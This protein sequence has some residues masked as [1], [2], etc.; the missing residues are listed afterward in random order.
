MKK[1]LFAILFSLCLLLVVSIGF[2]ACDGE[3]STVLNEYQ[4]T[5]AKYVAY[6]EAIGETPLSYEQWL[7]SIKGEDG[8]D[9]VG[10]DDMSFNDDG[11]LII[12]LTD[13]S[14]MNLGKLPK[15]EH[16][17]TDWTII[18]DVDCS[19]MGV[20]Y[21]TCERCLYEDYDF[22][23]ALGHNY[24]EITVDATCVNKGYVEH[25]CTE[26][27]YAHRDA[28]V[29]A[30]GAH[31]WEN[32]LCVSSVC[33]EETV[34]KTC[35]VCNKTET[36]VKGE[37]E[38]SYFNGECERCGKYN[39][40]EDLTKITESSVDTFDGDIA[41]DG[42]VLVVF[43]GA[44]SIYCQMLIDFLEQY[45]E[46]LKANDEAAMAADAKVVLVKISDGG[47]LDQN[48]P[49]YPIYQRYQ[50]YS[51]EGIPFLVMLDGGEVIGYMNGIYNSYDWLIDWLTNPTM[52]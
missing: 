14:Q 10:I 16:D 23:P 43:Y 29:D 47:Y 25:V 48:S 45:I 41:R 36:L 37:G 17:F 19:T 38:H 33:G 49:N 40:A 12:T 4:Q 35:L 20:K 15:C 11:E 5:Y 31:V 30:K 50:D 21:R 18:S 3:N 24:E 34:L 13:K 26:C 8:K 1:K 51:V 22:S 52:G 28:Y 6:A 9:G 44:Q 39:E 2:V 32:L 42:K 46:E 7:Q 27:G